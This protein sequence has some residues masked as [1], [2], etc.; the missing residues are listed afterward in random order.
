M[1]Y[2]FWNLDWLKCSSGTWN[3]TRLMCLFC[4]VHN[5]VFAPYSL[6]PNIESWY[7]VVCFCKGLIFSVFLFAVE[8]WRDI[9]NRGLS[10]QIGDKKIEVAK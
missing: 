1:K 4:I 8:V 5:I 3:F 2:T 7:Q 10:L 9:R 6:I